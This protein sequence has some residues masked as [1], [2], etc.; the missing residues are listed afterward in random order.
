MVRISSALGLCLLGM[1]VGAHF[2]I[3]H[4]AF[5][6]KNDEIVATHESHWEHPNELVQYR[7]N[8]ILKNDFPIDL[9]ELESL[10]FA[11]QFD[12]QDQVIPASLNYLKL[13][14]LA[15][16]NTQLSQAQLEHF[17]YWLSRVTT[18]QRRDSL[19]VLVDSFTQYQKAVSELSTQEL[20]R[21]AS[22]NQQLLLLTEVERLQS[23]YF[24]PEWI[25]VLFKEQNLTKR[26]LLKRTSVRRNSTLSD[27][28]KAKA[29]ARLQ[30]Q[31]KLALDNHKNEV[32]Q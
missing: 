17:K 23:V 2:F 10:I 1:T 12:Q 7:Q 31:Y 3:V 32:R 21:E 13:N 8:Q 26:Y 24:S 5:S 27:D 18:Q 29:M 19:Q 22:V 9:Y 30:T 4:N 15:D 14:L 25:K 11:L 20:L 28:E 6:S 16:A